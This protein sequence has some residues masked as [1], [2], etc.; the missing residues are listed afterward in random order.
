MI[1]RVLHESFRDAVRLEIEVE[2]KFNFTRKVNV[3]IDGETKERTFE[4]TML[5]RR[6]PG[7]AILPIEFYISVKAQQETKY[8]AMSQ[9]E[10]ALRMLQSGMMA[11]AQAVELMVFGSAKNNCSKQLKEQNEKR[12]ARGGATTNAPADSGKDREEHMKSIN[13]AMAQKMS[14]VDNA[15]GS[16]AEQSDPEFEALVDEISTLISGKTNCR[17]DLICRRR[18][19]T[20]R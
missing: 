14:A 6:A 12:R 4:S 17:R 1:A 7:N 2:R 10:L 11:P 15:P 18:Q 19:R 5:V 20:R 9:N 3:T 16:G 8:S 13:D